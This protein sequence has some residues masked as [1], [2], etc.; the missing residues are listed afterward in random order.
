MEIIVN[1]LLKVHEMKR[2]FLLL[3]AVLGLLPLAWAGDKKKKSTKKTENKNYIDSTEIQWLNWDEAQVRMKKQPRKVWVD[4]YTDWCGWCKKMDATTF[5]NKELIKYM[6]K[7]FYAIKFNAEKE[8]SIRFLGNLYYIKPDNRANDLA[9]HLMNNQLS[10]PTY[11]FM[12]ENFLNPSPIPGYHG[13]P[14]ME[15]FLMYLGENIYKTKKFP[16]FDQSYT[17]TWGE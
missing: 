6:N 12:E 15:K 3:V 9:V 7:N 8:D 1:S 2:V 4:V 5:K 10:Y 13:V 17:T 16:E 11:I 14:E